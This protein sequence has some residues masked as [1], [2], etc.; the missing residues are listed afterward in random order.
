MKSTLTHWLKFN[1]VGLIGAAVQLSALALFNRWMC[2]HYLLA[3]AA[4]LELTLLHNFI[5]HQHFTWPERKRDIKSD[6]T[7]NSE[8]S[9]LTRLLRF[10]LS[11]GLVSLVGNLVLMRLLVSH[12]HLP[13]LAANAIA[14]VTCSLANF[15]ISHKWVFAANPA[16]NPVTSPHA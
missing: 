3:S 9:I 8:S 15:C 2:G 16:P 6:S 4:A 7:R 5:W 13:L 12:A 14:I 1:L 11:N 10:H